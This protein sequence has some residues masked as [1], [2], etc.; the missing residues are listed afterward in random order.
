[1]PAQVLRKHEVWVQSVGDHVSSYATCLKPAASRILLP[2][3][4]S[5]ETA[6]LSTFAFSGNKA[7]IKLQPL[8]LRSRTILLPGAIR[9]RRAAQ[10][11]C[12]HTKASLCE[13]VP[14]RGLETSTDEKEWF[15]KGG[16]P[17]PPRMEPEGARWLFAPDLRLPVHRAMRQPHRKNCTTASHSHPRIR[18]G[19][20]TAA[21]GRDAPTPMYRWVA[22]GRHQTSSPLLDDKSMVIPPRFASL[23]S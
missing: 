5:L 4:P 2:S 23:A 18:T 3:E 22:L 9:C 14:N 6:K 15:A 13:K 17:F 1:M 10:A 16:H 12:L 21:M 8:P 19:I 20:P 7:R 11:R